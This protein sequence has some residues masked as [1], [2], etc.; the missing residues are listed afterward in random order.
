ML[1]Q[2]V[3]HLTFNQ[4]V[5]GSSPGQATIF[6]KGCRQAVRHKI[7]ILACV[8][9]NPATPAKIEFLRSHTA[10]FFLYSDLNLR[11]VGQPRARKEV[12]TDG[13]A[14]KQILPPQ[15]AKKFHFLLVLPPVAKA[16]PV[17][18]FFA[19]LRP[20]ANRTSLA[21]WSQLKLDFFR[22]HTTSFFVLFQI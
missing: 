17:V 21:I 15:P 20:N 18:H 9:S 3:E 10:S 19:I 14:T 7:L 22:S 12:W 5:P 16:S 13:L 11:C 6:L 1:A 4:G 2:L 8:G